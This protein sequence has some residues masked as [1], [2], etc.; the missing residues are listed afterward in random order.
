[1]L[2][3]LL[4]FNFMRAC[5]KRFFSTFFSP[6]FTH[7]CGTFCNRSAIVIIPLFLK[8]IHCTA[9][10]LMLYLWWFLLMTTYSWYHSRT[11]MSSNRRR[12]FATESHDPN[13]RHQEGR[14]SMGDCGRSRHGRRDSQPQ[15]ATRIRHAAEKRDTQDHRCNSTKEKRGEQQ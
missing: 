8:H 6:R 13:R 10:F 9:P 1:M 14:A 7:F 12:Y 3:S 11:N 15:A 2:L 4:E 5:L